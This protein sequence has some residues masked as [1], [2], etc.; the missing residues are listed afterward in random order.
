MLEEIGSHLRDFATRIG[1]T[2]E[3]FDAFARS[4]YNRY[5][6]SCFLYSR[7]CVSTIDQSWSTMPHKDLPS[8]LEGQVHRL[9]KRE[10]DR[11]KKSFGGEAIGRLSDAMRSARDL[12]MILREANEARK[13][14]D[15]RP[16]IKVTIDP[17]SQIRLSSFV[18][19]DAK[20][21]PTKVRFNCRRII[22]A[23]NSMK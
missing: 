20:D 9:L 22:V 16:E 15:Y 10:Y 11:R 23:W 8:L 14:A 1:L 7:E 5:Y 4:A 2:D 6:Y 19:D 17:T 18:L 12:A 3:R 13:V 21:W